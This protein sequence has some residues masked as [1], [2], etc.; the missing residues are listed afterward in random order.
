[1]GHDISIVKGDHLPKIS[2]P[3]RAPKI[4]GW[5]DYRAALDGQFAFAM[6]LNALPEHS[7]DESRRDMFGS[8]QKVI[9]EGT[10]YLWDR[11]SRT[12]SAALI[13]RCM[14]DGSEMEGLSGSVLCLGQRGDS[15][16]R[17]VLF[18]NFETPI[19]SQHFECNH[20]ARG[21]V[22]WSAFKGGFVLPD[23]VRSAQILCEGEESAAIPLEGQTWDV[24]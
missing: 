10:E 9:V 6:V 7:T 20:A 1:M 8:M 3:P 13:W 23:E 14:H 15:E 19:C 2:Q 22:S 21:D 17:A 24:E 5:G 11:K 12:Q 16:C 4:V 18:K